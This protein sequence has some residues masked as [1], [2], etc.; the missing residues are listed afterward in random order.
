MLA[1]KAPLEQGGHV[2]LEG[3]RVSIFS[4]LLLFFS[5]F[6]LSSAVWTI[7]PALVG[8]REGEQNGF[9]WR[10]RD[11]TVFSMRAYSHTRHHVHFVPF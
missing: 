10:C 1:I 9:S 11:M 3:I 7:Q 5:F 6:A 8:E 2:V 4:R